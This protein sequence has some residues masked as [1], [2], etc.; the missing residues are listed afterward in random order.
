MLQMKVNDCNSFIKYYDIIQIERHMGNYGY[1]NEFKKKQ[2][3][4]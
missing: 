4:F 2:L 3:K 1:K